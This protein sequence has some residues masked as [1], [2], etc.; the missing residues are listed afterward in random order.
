MSAEGPSDDRYRRWWS[1][2]VK[3]NRE[4]PV[5]LKFDAWRVIDRGELVEDDSM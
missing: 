1:M 5:L 3:G 4:A 2:G